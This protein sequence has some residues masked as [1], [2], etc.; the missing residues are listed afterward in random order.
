MLGESLDRP[1]LT[2][3]IATFEDDEHL[4]TGFLDPQLQ[5]E[6]LDLQTPLLPLVLAARHLLLVR[7]ALLPGIRELRRLQHAELVLETR[8]LVDLGRVILGDGNSG[9]RGRQVRSPTDRKSTSL[10]SSH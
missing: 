10:N 6:Q 1:A 2:G 5:L 8:Q 4:L 9:R 7:I 3:S